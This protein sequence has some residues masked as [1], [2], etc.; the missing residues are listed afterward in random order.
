MNTI[1]VSVQD[2]IAYLTL[3]RGSSNAINGEMVTE[4]TDMIRNLEADEQVGGVILTG[5][6]GFFSAGLDLIELYNY[7]EA[8][9]KA[10]WTDFLTMVSALVGFKKPLISAIGGHSPAGG[11]VLAICSDYRIMAEGKYIIGLNEVPV[12]IIVPDSIFHIYAFW[13]GQAKAYQSLLEGKLFRADE[14]LSIGLVDE[15]VAPTVLLTSAQR[16]MKQY[17]GF[18]WTT[19]QKS[20]QNLRKELL[21][22]VR[23]DQSDT[24]SEMLKQW[25]SPGTRSILQ[26]IIQNLQKKS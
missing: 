25:W 6:E 17:I 21:E 24:L 19:W 26:T 23:A 14:A 16:K 11:C 20:K 5:K 8:Q 12:G 4:L 15:V 22:K 9:I 13:L 7:N 3:N 18:D 2:H 1:H 10:F